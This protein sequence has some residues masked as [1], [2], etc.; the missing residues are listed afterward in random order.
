MFKN[1]IALLDNDFGSL[2]IVKNENSKIFIND[3]DLTNSG[4]SLLQSLNKD[5]CNLFLLV[6]ETEIVDTQVY[7]QINSILSYNLEKPS[8]VNSIPYKDNLETVLT[9]LQDDFSINP[10]ETVF[11]SSDRSSRHIS[12]KKGYYAV[13]HPKVAAMVVQGKLI[14]FVRMLTDRSLIDPASFSRS[15]TVLL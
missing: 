11:V 10:G 7:E 13:P 9:R 6:R 3:I 12:L 5:D 2:R 1:V 8:L 14:R 15:F 4:K